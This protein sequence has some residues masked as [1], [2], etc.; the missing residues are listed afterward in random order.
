M[1]PRTFD[2]LVSAAAQ[3]PTRR[4]ALRM[5][6]ASFLSAIFVGRAISGGAAQRSDRDQDGLFDDDEVQVYGT[7]PDRPD[8][9]GDGRDDGQEVYD[10]TD[11]LAGAAPTGRCA[12]GLT[13]C[14]GGVCADLSSDRNHCGACGTACPAGDAACYGGVC[15]VACFPGQTNC[16][17]YCVDG[18]R[19][20]A[21]AETVCGGRCVNLTYDP[22]NCG[23]C[24]EVCNS[25]EVCDLGECRI[26]FEGCGSTYLE[27]CTQDGDCCQG[28]ICL[29]VEGGGICYPQP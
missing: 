14:G 19:C 7:D 20:C 3:Q 26:Y 17:G 23:V 16:G 12:V 28:L 11:P 15:A 10:G 25:P 1:D 8:T 4:S 6:A 2:S 9:D 29:R 27:P 13:D 5:L 18:D 22:L 24:G 21:P